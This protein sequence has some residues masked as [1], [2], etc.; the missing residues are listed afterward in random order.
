MA[1]R[2]QIK[3]GKHWLQEESLKTNKILGKCNFPS[4][5]SS[6]APSSSFLCLL[7]FSFLFFFLLVCLL[8]TLPRK[9]ASLF[10]FTTWF[11]GLIDRKCDGRQSQFQASWLHFFAAVYHVCLV[12]CEG[13]VL[14]SSFPFW[15][16]PSEESST[17]L[18][19]LMLLFDKS[20]R[21]LGNYKFWKSGAGIENITFTECLSSQIMHSKD[22]ACKAE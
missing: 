17:L 1:V 6:P 15:R 3:Q 12:L 8:P 13:R 19:L 20:E 5:F 11:Y 22:I 9:K 10:V 2:N 18:L 21:W 7:L 14:I 4:F 16:K